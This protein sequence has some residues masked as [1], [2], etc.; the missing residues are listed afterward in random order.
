MKALARW[1]CIGVVLTLG[2]RPVEAAAA[3]LEAAPA[4]LISSAGLAAPL[5]GA[6]DLRIGSEE[7]VYLAS[8]REG[9]FRSAFEGGELGAAAR[10]IAPGRGADQVWLTSRLARSERYAAIAADLFRAVVLGADYS[11][12]ARAIDLEAFEDL[13]LHG[14][15]LAFTGLARG[16]RGAS[17]SPDG[18]VAWVANLA[19]SKLEPRAVAWAFSGAGASAFSNCMAFSISAIRFLADGRLLF[20]PGAEPGAF[21]LDPEQGYRTVASWDTRALGIGPDCAISDEK[22]QLL[23][24][25][26]LV[27]WDWLNRFETVEEILPLAAGPVLVTRRVTS[28]GTEF[29]AVR[30][31]AGGATESEPLPVSSSSRFAHLRGDVR[32]GEALLVTYEVEVRGSTGAALHRLSWR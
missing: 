18:A 21:L 20:V 26:P 19:D 22:A 10:V 31:L 27:R 5:A 29:R 24:R 25:D 4:R 17:M 12:S 8:P 2:D 23:A 16:D 13:D 30:L 14:A 15:Q 6:V 11:G 9:V 28:R 3:S 7:T 1:I 32:G